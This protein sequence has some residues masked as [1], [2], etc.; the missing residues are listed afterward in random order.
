MIIL[1]FIHKI[2]RWIPLSLIA[3]C[4]KALQAALGWAFIAP[5]VKGDGHLP[6]PPRSLF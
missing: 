2:I 5:F 4:L 1:K 6:Y 3:L